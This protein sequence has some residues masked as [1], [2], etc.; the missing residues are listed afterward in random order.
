MESIQVLAKSFV[1][2]WINVPENSAISYQVKVT[3]KSIN[4]GLYKH[5]SSGPLVSS[6]TVSTSAASALP[7]IEERLRKTGF[8]L[9]KS[10][11]MQKPGHLVN[12]TFNVPIGQGGTYAIVFDNTFSKT[13][14]KT[15]LLH[16]SVNPLSPSF[17]KEA[18][19]E[20]ASMGDQDSSGQRDNISVNTLDNSVANSNS[21][22]VDAIRGFITGPLMKKRRKK[23][24]GYARRRFELDHKNATLN[25]YR[26]ASSSTLRGSMLINLCVISVNEK[27]RDIIIDS[28][29]EVWSLRALDSND[30][31]AWVRALDEA[32]R[33]FQHKQQNSVSP[34]NTDTVTGLSSSPQSVNIWNDLVQLGD[35][36]AALSRVVN[37]RS[38]FSPD[39]SSDRSVS[40]SSTASVPF[41][42]SRSSST[43]LSAASTLT[44]QRKPSFWKRHSSFRNGGGSSESSEPADSVPTAGHV[45]A[46][47][48]DSPLPLNNIDIANKLSML[49]A[50]YQH[51][52]VRF[53]PNTKNTALEASN[54]FSHTRNSPKIESDLFS[55]AES[56]YDAVDSYN[57]AIVYVDLDSQSDSD[58]EADEY[59][60]SEISSDSESEGSLS[61]AISC[62]SVG[63]LSVVPSVMDGDSLYPISLLTEPIPRRKTIPRAA[64]NAPSIIGFLRK[65]VGKDFS[66]IAVPVAGNEP[67]NVL[68]RFSEMLEYSNLLDGAIGL[69]RSDG[70]RILHIAAFAVSYLS[71]SRS[72][73]RCLRKPFNPLLGETF[74]LVREDRQFRLL[75]EKVGHKP[76]LMAIQA[77]SCTGWSLVHSPNPNQKFWGKSAEIVTNGPVVVTLP[78]D[79]GP[80]VFQ[81]T[82]P[83]TFLRNIIAGEK[84]IEPVDSFTV[85]SSL[86]E[87]AVITFKAG[88]VFSGRSEEFFVKVFNAQGLPLPITASGKWTESF[89]V[90]N[91]GKTSVVWEAGNLVAQ[92]NKC[93]GLTEFAAQLNEIT[94]VE[95]SLM[96][97]T[98]TRLRPDQRLYEQGEIERPESLKLE[99]EEHQ[100]ERRKADEA[101]NKVWTPTFFDKQINN[102]QELYVLKQGKDSYWHRRKT[103][104][105]DGLITLW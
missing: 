18:T 29:M 99:L 63:V 36:L 95:K 54:D 65:N 27:T 101:D 52:L 43:S 10:Y 100:R 57:S 91:N 25:Y 58:N 76:P 33:D 105:W 64:Q 84:Y 40:A 50:Q 88:G 71:S 21:P 85:H 81:W 35:E 83:T 78:V 77:E 55:D 4:F 92:A 15:V 75:A 44:P 103:G 79:S 34:V 80:E 3:K 47:A 68:Q 67:I 28:G 14:P 60:K 8:T 49:S 46:S 62:A 41:V 104:N 90:N 30:L 72:R 87:R 82:H 22:R 48:G 32:K 97:P 51:L 94:T 89:I 17:W 53:K 2:K 96:A 42:N 86:G 70:Q 7:D 74:E 11:T 73:D 31:K 69:P 61:P 102:G 93:F 19:R 16:L 24:Q 13:T 26:D 45:S 66:S 56:F 23:L 98:D 12:D 39:F 59:Q 5:D 37:T 6:G 1:I 38:S 9:I 20:T